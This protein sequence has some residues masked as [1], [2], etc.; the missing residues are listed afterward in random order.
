MVLSWLGGSCC[1]P[2]WLP[3]SCWIFLWPSGTAGSHTLLHQAGQVPCP[4]AR[5]VGP[6]QCH[7]HQLDLTLLCPSLSCSGVAPGGA[8]ARCGVGLALTG[9]SA[10][11]RHVHTTCLGCSEL[12]CVPQCHH[13]TATLCAPDAPSSAASLGDSTA[14][15]H[16]ASGMLRAQLCPSMAPWHV[17]SLPLSPWGLRGA[18]FRVSR[19]STPALSGAAAASGTAGWPVA[20]GQR[21]AT[22]PGR[23][24]HRGGTRSL[25]RLPEPDSCLISQA[26]GGRGMESFPGLPGPGRPHASCSAPGAARPRRPPGGL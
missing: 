12:S 21:G 10:P 22:C 26:Q 3:A 11:P 13:V 4:T 23:Q 18:F 9:P 24:A 25:R 2:S 8:G 7:C 1:C 19:H 20:P 5:T 14:Q 6:S 16:H 15:P 17:P